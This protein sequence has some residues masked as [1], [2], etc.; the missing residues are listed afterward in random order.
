[1]AN[2]YQF[3]ATLVESAE[4]GE[5]KAQVNAVLL[6]VVESLAAAPN[7]AEISATLAES[8]E[9]SSPPADLA[10]ILIEAIE[11]LDEASTEGRMRMS[12]M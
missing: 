11:S 10:A 2:E 7:Y 3:Q 5:P 12:L 8:I 1:M 9:D 6:E 4:S